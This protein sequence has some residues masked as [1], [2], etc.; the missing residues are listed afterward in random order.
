M[1][2]HPAPGD[3][4]PEVQRLIVSLS[5]HCKSP[6]LGATQ[7][8]VTRKAEAGVYDMAALTSLAPVIPLHS[9][10]NLRN[11]AAAEDQLAKLYCLVVIAL[12][13]HTPGVEPGTCDTC[14]EPWPCAQMRRAVHLIEVF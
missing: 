5:L 12:F 14:L 2:R 11:Q 7:L 3:R 13:L 9:K 10:A 1:S 6:V 8:L 4:L